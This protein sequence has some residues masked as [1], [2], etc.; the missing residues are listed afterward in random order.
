[1]SVTMAFFLNRLT[2]TFYTYEKSEM[3]KQQFQKFLIINTVYRLQYTQSD[4]H[5]Y[6]LKQINCSIKTE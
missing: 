4:F 1:M 3:N 5:I 6:H 2:L